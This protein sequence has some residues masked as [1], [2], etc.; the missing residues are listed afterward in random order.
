MLFGF[1]D[2]KIFQIKLKF[3]LIW[4]YRV[5]YSLRVLPAFFYNALGYLNENLTQNISVRKKH[6]VNLD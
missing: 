2:I 6:R 5:W 3:N 4:I 1:Y